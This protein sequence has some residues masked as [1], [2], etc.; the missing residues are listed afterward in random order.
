[1]T[2]TIKILFC[3]IISVW[4]TLPAD[5]QTV[6]SLNEVKETGLHVIEI[7]TDGNEKLPVIRMTGVLT[8][9]IRRVLFR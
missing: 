2:K 9:T 5:S 6:I 8:I 7:T 3:Y 4:L 1:M